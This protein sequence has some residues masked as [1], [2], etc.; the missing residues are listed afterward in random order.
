MEHAGLLRSVAE[1]GRVAT[2]DSALRAGTF[3][4]IHRKALFEYLRDRAVRGRLRQQ[5]VTSFHRSVPY[6]Q[7]MVAEHGQ[8]LRS[9]G[10]FLCTRHLG[11]TVFHDGVFDDPFRQYEDAYGEYFGA[12]CDLRL[13]LENGTSEDDLSSERALLFDLKHEV[14]R[15]REAILRLPPAMRERRRMARLRQ[16][17]GERDRRRW[18]E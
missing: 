3:S 11:I 6:M 2:Q 14:N 7:A 5:L 4:L 15:R 1:H 13:A 18:N 10:S 16:R 17:I 8:F 9:A 12:F